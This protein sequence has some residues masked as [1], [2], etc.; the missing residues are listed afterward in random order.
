IE[1]FGREAGDLEIPD[2]ADLGE[3][4]HDEDGHDEEGHDD[5]HEGEDHDEDEIPGVLA[6]SFLESQ[7]GTLGLAWIGAKGSFGVS[8]RGFDTLYGIPGG[9]G[10]GQGHEDDHDEGEEHEEGEHEEEEHDDHGDE[11]EETV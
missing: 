4:E 2:D 10:H 11:E 9:H 6:N 3:D 1:A 5:E 7:G 8:V